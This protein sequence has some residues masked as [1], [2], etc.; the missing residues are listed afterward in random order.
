[1]VRGE[2]CGAGKFKFFQTFG[3]QYPPN[4]HN[5]SIYIHYVTLEVVAQMKLARMSRY[6]MINQMQFFH[7]KSG[8][9]IGRRGKLVTVLS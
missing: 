8:K 5:I 4:P 3:F 7:E 2:K 6:G 1:V 9:N